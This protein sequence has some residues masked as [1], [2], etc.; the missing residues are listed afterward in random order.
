MVWKDVLIGFTV[1]GIILAAVPQSFFQALFLGSGGDNAANP[2]FWLVL[3]QTLVAVRSWHWLPEPGA[4]IAC[5][6]SPGMMQA[7]SWH[8]PAQDAVV[9]VQQVNFT[10]GFDNSQV[11]TIR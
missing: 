8:E 3:Q 7:D 9:L 2:D 11:H 4:I 10:I 1:A 6:N 5:I